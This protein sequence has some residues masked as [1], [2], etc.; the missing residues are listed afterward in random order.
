MKV[1]ELKILRRLE[2]VF[3]VEDV[4]YDIIS[5]TFVYK[6]GSTVK[7]ITFHTLINTLEE[8]ELNEEQRDLFTILQSL[9]SSYFPRRFKQLFK[10]IYHHA[11]IDLPHNI[12]I[13]QD[14][15]E[16]INN[17]ATTYIIYDDNW[18]SIILEF[19]KIFNISLQNKKDILDFED[20]KGSYHQ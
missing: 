1:R 16:I 15:I 17:E 18:E 14:G 8:M 5:K 19:E 2:V 9:N 4:S 12:Y 6:K 20:F 11:N 7:E 10:N 3:D 13:N